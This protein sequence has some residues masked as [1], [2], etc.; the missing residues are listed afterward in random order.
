MRFKRGD[1]G[2]T[3]TTAA[4]KL[5]LEI[6]NHGT[7]QQGSPVQTIQPVSPHCRAWYTVVNQNQVVRLH[8][9]NSTIV[10]TGRIAADLQ[11]DPSHK[12]MLLS[13][14]ERT[15][16]TSNINTIVSRSIPGNK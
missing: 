12:A 15:I 6:T 16:A 10:N 4:A 11:Y 9:A 7:K 3:R 13:P 14:T 1:F 8:A 5:A 2:R